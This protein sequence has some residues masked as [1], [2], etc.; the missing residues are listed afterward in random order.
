MTKSPHGRLTIGCA[1]VLLLLAVSAASAQREGEDYRLK[2]PGREVAIERG[3][4]PAA[5]DR[6]DLFV[7]RFDGEPGET[8]LHSLRERG[9][10]IGDYL[11]DSCYW[12][13]AEGGLISSDLIG[14]WAV[15]KPTAE[16]KIVPELAGRLAAAGVERKV[17]V[18]ISFLPDVHIKSVQELLLEEGIGVSPRELLYGGRLHL[19]LTPAQTISL[20]ASNHV[21]ILEPGPRHKRVL[22]NKSGRQTRSFFARRAFGI[23]GASVAVAIWDGGEVYRHKEF[24]DRLTLSESSYISEH[25]THVA[26]TIAAEGKKVS[27]TGAAPAARIYSY[28]FDG[29]LA[30]EM[31]RAVTKY[32]I[33]VSNNSW[34][35]MTGWEYFYHPD[36]QRY[37]WGW[38]GDEYFGAYD[39]E[40]AAYDQLVYRNN[41]IIVFSAGNDRGDIVATSQYWDDIHGTL[42]DQTVLD[43]DGPYVTVGSTGSAKKVIAVGAT[44]GGKQMSSFSSWGPTK[45][46]RVKPEVTAP[47]V[48][49]WSTLPNNK[50]G[51]LSGTSMSAPAVTG[52]IALLVDLWR[53]LY[54][55]DP[56]PA[57]I[58]GII[59]VTAKD[60]GKRG[61]DYK[62]GFGALAVEAAARLI[63]SSAE[64]RVI[65]ED[66]IHKT[67]ERTKTYTFDV[68]SGVETL[69]VCLAWIDPPA[70][71]RSRTTLVN[72]LDAR[73]LSPGGKEFLPWTLDKDNPKKKATAGVNS[74]DN[75]EIVEVKN[76]VAGTWTAEVSAERIGSGSRQA[77]ALIVLTGQ[78]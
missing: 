68:P 32:A 46:G 29:D 19:Q 31:A 54:Y 21:R 42:V 23:D 52:G 33:V 27:A 51:I 26:G 49:I 69:K 57:A 55:G 50:Y 12:V 47:G 59:A 5:F 28:D 44:S 39:S 41:L 70:S 73:L 14:V 74:V 67:R 61:P 71:P 34:G 72:D 15:Y 25:S 64:D 16:D 4:M 76:P 53:S 17:N 63:N 66:K 56:S 40:S 7:F 3:A 75:I 62:Y 11:G 36:Y 48:R 65:I 6:K 37:M 18:T 35:Y 22:N 58:R 30:S 2:L 9:L 8:L 13:R 24:G 10:T 78:K 77:F 38:F 20:A 45:D 1:V 43:K 60:Y